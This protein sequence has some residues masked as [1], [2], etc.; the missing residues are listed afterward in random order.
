MSNSKEPNIKKY[1]V[2][3]WFIINTGEVFY[4]GKGCKDRYKTRKRENR[5]FMLMLETHE[6]DSKIIADG[7]TENEAYKLEIETIKYYKE[8]SNFRIVNVTDGGDDP[9]TFY[10]DES[11]SRRPEVRA[12]IKA[13]NIKNWANPDYKEKMK[14]A[15]KDFYN[16]EKGKKVASERTLS[17]WEKDD[18]RFR[19][20]SNMTAT[21]RTEEFKIKHSKTMKEAYS[22]QEVRDKVT[23]TNNGSSRRVKQYSLGMELIAE[24]ETLLEAENKTGISFKGISKVLHGHRKTTGGFIWKFADDKKTVYKRKKPYAKDV[25]RKRVPILQYDLKNNLLKEYESVASACTQNSFTSRTNIIANL[26]GR[27]KSAYGFIWKYKE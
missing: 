24:Y 16:T 17:N 25:N 23:G 20:V 9:P 19:V 27:T 14:K 10:G 13:S 11:H 1:Y 6:C 3:E 22:S 7:L 15:F 4:I 8:N 5:F 21:M 2:Y 12:K 18:F 26:K